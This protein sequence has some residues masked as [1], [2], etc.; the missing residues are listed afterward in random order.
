MI[1]VF[2]PQ[3][4]HAEVVIVPDQVPGV[5]NQINTPSN[6]YGADDG[7]IQYVVSPGITLDGSGF[8]SAGTYLF[9]GAGTGGGGDAEVVVLLN[10][11]DIR[12]AG[13]AGGNGGYGVGWSG[14]GGGGGAGTPIGV[15]GD[16][17]GIAAGGVDGDEVGNGGAGGLG[18]GSTGTPGTPFGDDPGNGGIAL[19]LGIL[20][21]GNPALL[22][23]DNQG[24]IW[25]GGGGGGQGDN[26][27]IPDRNGKAGGDAGEEGTWSSRN[28][29][30]DAGPGIYSNGTTIVWLAGD[31][32][33]DF[34]GGVS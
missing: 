2:P 22:Y 27:G 7:V 4:V 5:I 21:S 15:G 13:G 1:G 8:P 17:N 6:S 16:G 18:N 14:G 12:G 11:G 3:T 26:I 34:E 9:D 28:K 25:G 23:V 20:T 19:Y 31:S 30:G 10:A 33:P 24:T 32:S 29:H